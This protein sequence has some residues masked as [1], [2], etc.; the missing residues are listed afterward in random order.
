MEHPL[1]SGMN[2]S[3]IPY[4]TLLGKAL[5]AP[6]RLIPNGWVLPILQGKMRGMRWIVGS[7]NHGCWLGS[8][9]YEKRKIFEE[10]VAEGNVVYDIGAN[11]GF[12][13]LLASRLVGSEGKVFAFEPLPTNLNYLEKHVKL[14]DCAN[15]TIL[16]YALLEKEG[17]VNF[18]GEGST[19]HVSSNGKKIVEARTL[20]ELVSNKEIQ[21]ANIIKMDIEGAE[22]KALMGGQ[23]FFNSYSPVLL[24]ATHGQSTHQ[25]CIE[26]LR[27]WGYVLEA[28][29]KGE[30]QNT[31]ELIAFK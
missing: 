16:R 20:D 25:N 2:F 1:Q 29:G 4:D 24:L 5:R 17:V 13:T 7:S 10:E 12:Y 3:R 6:L 8:F 22:V 9:E 19:A 21:P 27:D 26:L 11:V 15:V 31:S 18:A 14:N 30:V 28:V 23:D